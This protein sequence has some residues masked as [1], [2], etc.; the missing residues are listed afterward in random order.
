MALM[1][2]D[3]EYILAYPAQKTPKRKGL[4]AETKALARRVLH[5]DQDESKRRDSLDNGLQWLLGSSQRA[6]HV[7]DA[8]KDVE[9]AKK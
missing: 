5:P 9:R 3:T 6:G 7:S 8:S 4:S 2:S 1:Q